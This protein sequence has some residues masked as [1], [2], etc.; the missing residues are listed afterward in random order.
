MIVTFYKCAVFANR[1]V[2]L[3]V[4]RVK[5]KSVCC[6]QKNAKI[7]QCTFM[8]PKAQT[9]LTPGKNGMRFYLKLADLKSL[10][11]GVS[12]CAVLNN[13]CTY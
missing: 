3:G 11:I 4:K 5:Q 1:R 13:N 9:G 7:K 6:L 8:P 2:K 10:T 12:K